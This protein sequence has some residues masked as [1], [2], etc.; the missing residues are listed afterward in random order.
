MTFNLPTQLPCPHCGAVAYPTDQAIRASQSGAS[1]AT[2][3]FKCSG[4]GCR[5]LLNY[6]PQS[7]RLTG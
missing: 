2:V 7:G 3:P 6:S 4:P 5:R 1:W